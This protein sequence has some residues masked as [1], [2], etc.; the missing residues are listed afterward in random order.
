MRSSD[1]DTIIDGEKGKAEGWFKKFKM[2]GGSPKSV[3]P[4]NQEMLA[5]MMEI[6]QELTDDT[7]EIKE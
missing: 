5:E 3:K 2:T 7:K 4:D 1:V 6:L